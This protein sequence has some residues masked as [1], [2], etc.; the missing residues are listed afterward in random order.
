MNKL[1][2]EIPSELFAP[3]ESSSYA[4]EYSVGTFEFGPDEYFA[5]K[6]FTWDVRI[7]N[8]G[9]ALLV[10]GSIRGELTTSCARCLSDVVLDISGEVEGYFLIEGEGEAPDDMEEDE[11][12]VLPEDNKLNLEPLLL[13]GIYVELP[14]IPLC[15]EDCAGICPTCGANL[16]DGACG[17]AAEDPAEGEGVNPNNPFSVLKGLKFD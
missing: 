16:N 4:G 14:L 9:G 12:D 3:A 2:I 7:T 15:R 10:S 13:A 8:V 11:F 6:P 5:Q 17:C 1:V